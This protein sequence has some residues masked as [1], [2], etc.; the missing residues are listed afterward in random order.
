MPNI[1]MI[2]LIKLYSCKHPG[3]LRICLKSICFCTR[4]I[5]V[6][7]NS[8]FSLQ[9]CCRKR[10]LQALFTSWIVGIFIQRFTHSLDLPAYITAAQ[11]CEPD[12]VALAPPIYSLI[13]LTPWGHVVPQPCVLR[14]PFPHCVIMVCHQQRSSVQ[15]FLYWNDVMLQ[16]ESPHTHRPTNERQRSIF[17]FFFTWKTYVYMRRIIKLNVCL[18]RATDKSSL[19]ILF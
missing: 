13:D 9:V 18:L 19:I 8:V 7:L 15:S 16:L 11:C 5:H 17:S 6:S 12:P 14:H 10:R 2:I 1:E 4:I 3:W